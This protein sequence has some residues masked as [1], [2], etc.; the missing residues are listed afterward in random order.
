MALLAGP[1]I[2]H[3]LARRNARRM[4]FPATRF[5]RPTQAAA[6]RLRR[7][8]DLALLGLRLAIV[9]A[10]V[11]AAAHPLVVTAGAQPSGTRASRAR[12]SSIRRGT[13]RRPRRQPATAARYRLH[14]RQQLADQESASAFRSVQIES[15][16][17]AD[18]LARAARWLIAAP[19]SRREVV[20]ISDFRM[21]ALDRKSLDVLP[22]EVG[23][24]FVR[25][26]TPPA[27]RAAILSPI[28][29]GATAAGN[30]RSP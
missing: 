20:V 6:V 5:V 23:I 4:V 9:A 26:G 7:P 8:C 17:I 13:T 1:V 15:G 16:D 29:G 10:A 19:P 22:L 27:E 2:V 28:E 25:A 3:L 30:R 24:R 18:A 21:G 12:S 11:V 14:P